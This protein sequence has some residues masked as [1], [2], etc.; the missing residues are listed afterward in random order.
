MSADQDCRRALEDAMRLMSSARTEIAQAIV[1]NIRTRREAAEEM[2]ER[3]ARIAETMK[4]SPVWISKETGMPN[5]AAIIGG[6]YIAAAIRAL[7]IEE[8]KP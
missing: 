4:S 6:E 3:A 2:R 7:P 8:D 1:D 5:A